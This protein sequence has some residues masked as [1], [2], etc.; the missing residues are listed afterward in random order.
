MNSPVHAPMLGQAYQ[1][2]Y[3]TTDLDR[4]LDIFGKQYGIRDFMVV[5]KGPALPIDGGG[6][7]VMDGALAWAG[8]TMIEIVQPISGNVELFADWLPKDRFALRFH[9]IAVPVRTDAGW[10]TVRRE[11]EESGKRIVFSV[12]QPNS[13]A[14]YVDTA[15]DLGHYLEYLYVEG[16][17]SKSWLSYIP[18]NIPGYELKF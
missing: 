9:H 10:Q 3:A 1:L 5:K 16:D 14:M 2:G 17:I 18:Q 8:P 7:L 11:A 4:A 12:S 13:R 15:D 6:E